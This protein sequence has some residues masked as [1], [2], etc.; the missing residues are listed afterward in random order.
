MKVS[1]FSAFY[2]FR[3]GI[4]QFNARLYRSLETDHGVSA[5][6]FKKQYPDLLF[7]GTSQY[8]S[9][10][11]KAD[12]IPAER[13][14]S[15]FNPFTYW[16][17]ARKVKS[18][19]PDILILNYWMTIFGPFLGIIASRQKRTTKR[20]AL[21]HNLIP[22]ER[23]FFDRAFTR[24]FVKRMDG[25]VVLSEAVGKDLLE[26]KPDARI[27]YLP[28]PWYDHFGEKIG[29]ETAREKLGIAGEKRTILFFGLIRDY[30]GLD[31]LI[32][33]FSALDS[34][35]Q[36]IIAG[37]VYSGKEKYVNQISNSG[38]KDRILFLDRYV[39]DDE[40]ATLYSSADVCVLPYRTGTQSGV[41]A[42]SF[43][44]DVPVI[45]TNV[46]GLKETVGDK[47]LG[48][49]IDSADSELLKNAIA[50]YFTDGMSEG[51]VTNIQKEKQNNSW[52]H[53]ASE[54]IRFSNSL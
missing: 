45:A 17:A 13:I 50:E 42:A 38:A 15:S 9:D 48:K 24:F 36:L 40:V 10:A 1:I 28:H 44:F 19:E 31:V 14:V 11:D 3:G 35:Y 37:E 5:F 12:H 25:Y 21:I 33:A 16:S 54:L 30:K 18:S 32:S 34:S 2:P 22:H 43:H 52:S 29:K 7:P 39:P 46:G 26:L 8:V 4:A 20:I 47:G 27:K 6:T 51:Y 23:R 41:T 49:I 53:F